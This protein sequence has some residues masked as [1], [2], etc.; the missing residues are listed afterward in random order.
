MPNPPTTKAARTRVLYVVLFIYAGI[1][2]TYEVINSISTIIGNFN[3]RNQV[4]APF[5]LYGNFDL[6]SVSGGHACRA[7]QG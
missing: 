7:Y 2:G 3:L 1:A 5:Q 6:Q 4:Q